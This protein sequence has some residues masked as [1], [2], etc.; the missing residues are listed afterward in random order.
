MKITNIFGV[1]FLG[2]T[3]LVFASCD[4]ARVYDQSR[5]IPETGWNQDSLA[6]FDVEISDTAIPYNFYINLRHTTDYRYRNFYLFL[7]TMFP[8][9][10]MSRDT[11]EL[12]LADKTG[13]WLG[14]GFGSIKDLQIPVRRN[15]RFP[16]PGTYQ[17]QIEQGMREKNLEDIKNVGLRIEKAQ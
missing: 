12:I 1:F 16:N 8:N 14:S 3:L 2:I 10:R 4:P 15:L 17:F 5:T 7:N 11:I 6:V 13:K 9:G